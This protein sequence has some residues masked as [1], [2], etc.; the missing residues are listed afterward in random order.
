MSEPKQILTAKE[1]QQRNHEEMS[2]NILYAAREV[3]RED[4]V[5]ALNLQEIA[6]RVGM[7]APSLYNYYPNKNAIYDALFA[8]G[9]RQYRERLE[10]LLDEY[11]TTWDGLQRIMEGYLIHALEHPEM[12]QLLFE[13]PVPGFEPSAEG[14]AESRRLLDVA[15]KM[16]EDAKANGT[17]TSSVSVDDTMNLFIALMHGVTALHIANE[18]HLPLGEG[19]FGSLM[20]II[21]NLLKSAWSDK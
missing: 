15:R 4:G 17:I 6:R 9:M 10:T 5:A 16:T 8:M 14:Q 2:E 1:R 18:P 3:M 13:R 19:R 7:R 12:Y 11:G 21:T 20:P